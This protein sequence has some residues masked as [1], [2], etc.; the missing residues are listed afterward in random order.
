MKVLIAGGAGF[1]GSNF[2]RL[3]LTKGYKVCVI[4]KLTYAGRKANLKG[5]LKDI[6]FIKGDITC[7][8]DVEKAVKGCNVV[9]NFAA[10]SHVDKSIKNAGEF[11]ETNFYGSYVL[12]SRALKEKIDLFLQISSDEVYGSLIK[13]SCKE[14]AV[15]NPTS[16]Y[17]ATK[18][19]ADL[20]CL[21]FHKTYGLPVIIT[22][23]SNNY[24]SY[25]Y[26]EKLI[27]LSVIK[28]IR[29]EK[30]PLYGNG[31]NIRDWIDVGDNCRAIELI[32]S[33]GEA[34]EIYNISSGVK[35]KNI[36]V[37]RGIIKHLNKKMS[38]IKYVK[39]RPNNDYRYS[40]NSSKVQFLGWI[41]LIKF[42]D[43]FKKTIDW[44]YDNKD[45]WKK[46]V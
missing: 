44:Y 39:D 27:P 22:R 31:S 3:L 10:E 13:G 12:L 28:A 18:A 1:I 30:I 2:T 40:M 17:A 35:K 24:G 37:V 45:W 4:D 38:L 23:S 16:P 46:V 34:G 21:S 36:D 32:L 42:D 20:L 9:I 14:T 41:P 5:V 26:P 8:G 19:S 7:S 25:Q 33:K 29:G 43:G 6:K 11:V 15:L